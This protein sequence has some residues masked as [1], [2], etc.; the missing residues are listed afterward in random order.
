MYAPQKTSSAVFDVKAIV[1]YHRVY[2]ASCADRLLHGSPYWRGLRPDLEGHQSGWTVPYS[3]LQHAV[4]RHKSQT[5]FKYGEPFISSNYY[6][7][8]KEKDRIYYY[9]YRLPRMEQAPED[10]ETG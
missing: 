6:L 10:K 5:R 7:V 3:T 9:V 2:A 1:P 8:V 4:R